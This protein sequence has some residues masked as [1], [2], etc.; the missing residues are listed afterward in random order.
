MVQSS[1]VAGADRSVSCPVIGS[2]LINIFSLNHSL[3]DSTRPVLTEV[4]PE[5]DTCSWVC[6]LNPAWHCSTG[7][8]H[9]VSR[10][11]SFSSGSYIMFVFLRIPICS[12][13]INSHCIDIGCCWC[14][15]LVHCCPRTAG[16]HLPRLERNERKAINFIVQCRRP[17]WL[18]KVFPTYSAV[19]QLYLPNISPLTRELVIVLRLHPLQTKYQFFKFYSEGPGKIH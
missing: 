17:V 7:D 9:Q 16:H 4:K 6:E 2:E 5:A 10:W 1:L 18:N 13:L 12:W 3:S 14:Y 8:E 19:F 11:N 15:L